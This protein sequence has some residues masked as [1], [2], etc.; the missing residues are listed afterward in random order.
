MPGTQADGKDQS[1]G[2]EHLGVQRMEIKLLL[3]NEGLF[4][5]RSSFEFWVHLPPLQTQEMINAVSMI[6]C[7]GSSKHLTFSHFA[8]IGS[9]SSGI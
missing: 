5:K 3:E 7:I 1:K 2:F 9:Q 8:S 4:I 6:F